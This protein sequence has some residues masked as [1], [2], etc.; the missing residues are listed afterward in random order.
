MFAYCCWIIGFLFLV[1]CVCFLQCILA[2]FIIKKNNEDYERFPVSSFHGEPVAH[3]HL[4][5][6]AGLLV[7]SKPALFT[8]G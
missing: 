7:A 5:Q 2:A 3:S 1:F 6:P 8:K 4:S